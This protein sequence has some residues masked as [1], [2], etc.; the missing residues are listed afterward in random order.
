MLGHLTDQQLRA[1][2]WGTSALTVAAMVVGV[3][4]GNSGLAIF[5][6]VMQALVAITVH[7][8]LSARIVR[9]AD[10][11]LLGEAMSGIAS[12][13]ARAM[14]TTY[15]WGAAAML[16]AYY[17]TPLSWQH[18]WQYGAGMALV[19]LLLMAYAR[20]VIS[21]GNLFANPRWLD[22]ARIATLLQG[23]AAL[24]GVVLLVLSG[25]LAAGRD[26]WAANVVFVAGGVAIVVQSAI[27][28]ANARR[29][30]DD[31]RVA[32]STLGPRSRRRTQPSVDDKSNTR[33]NGC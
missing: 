15:G 23:V 25:K 17:L 31:A 13:N 18:A 33:N 5:A 24:A 4:L 32:S 29:P 12:F 19:A 27:A 7:K 11:G 26:D 20:Q 21:A 6:G 10:Q 14:A 16:A 1:W 9:R 2:L 3:L 8:T 28:L 30:S 22:A